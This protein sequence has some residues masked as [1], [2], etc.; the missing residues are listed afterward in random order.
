VHGAVLVT[1]GGPAMV[2]LA[3]EDTA[4]LRLLKSKARV[5]SMTSKR[6]FGRHRFDIEVSCLSERDAALIVMLLIIAHE[7][8]KEVFAPDY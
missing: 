8:A 3:N 7:R 5:A 2:L 4:E 6:S 1:E